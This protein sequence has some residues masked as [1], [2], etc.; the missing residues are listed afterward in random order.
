MAQALPEGPTCTDAPTGHRRI[1][2][3]PARVEQDLPGTHEQYLADRLRVHAELLQ[4]IVSGDAERV[5]TAMER[6]RGNGNANAE[7]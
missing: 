4:A 2:D 3:L 6:H 1:S 5:A 7:V